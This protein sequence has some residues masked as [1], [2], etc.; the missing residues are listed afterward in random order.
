MCVLISEK[1]D[2]QELSATLFNTIYEKVHLYRTKITLSQ[3]E[4]VFTMLFHNP[5]PGSRPSW[6]VQHC[7]FLAFLYQAGHHCLW[8]H[9]H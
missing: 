2:V 5:S 3:H 6:S 4:S 8:L 9:I 1:E 7:C